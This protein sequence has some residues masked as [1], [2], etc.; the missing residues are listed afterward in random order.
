MISIIDT[1]PI[2]QELMDYPKTL[3]TK[4]FKEWNT[5]K[6]KIGEIYRI[7]SYLT[8]YD[9]M[10]FDGD[11]KRLYEAYDSEDQCA[12]CEFCCDRVKKYTPD[13]DCD[14]CGDDRNWE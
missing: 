14:L 6:W 10:I 3:H 5:P 2:T 13:C 7:D 1:H 8:D 12:W 11:W 4:C 9:R